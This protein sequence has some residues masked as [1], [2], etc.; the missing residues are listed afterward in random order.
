MGDRI[1]RTADSERIDPV[2]TALL[3]LWTTLLAIAFFALVVVD[4]ASAAAF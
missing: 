4:N 2:R 3:G 1:D